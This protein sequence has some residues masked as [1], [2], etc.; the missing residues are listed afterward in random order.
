MFSMSVGAGYSPC[1]LPDPVCS[2]ICSFDATEIAEDQTGTPG[3]YPDL[4]N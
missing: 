2:N 3:S 1:L 4:Q